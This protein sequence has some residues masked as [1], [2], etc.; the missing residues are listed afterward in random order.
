M[1]WGHQEAEAEAT[2][3]GQLAYS[4]WNLLPVLTH[5]HPQSHATLSTSWLTQ[6]SVQGSRFL[7]GHVVLHQ[8][9]LPRPTQFLPN[10]RCYPSQ[11]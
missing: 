7:E 4:N 8:R 9:P 5:L 3:Q 10:R 1:A 11:Y 2:M 6:L